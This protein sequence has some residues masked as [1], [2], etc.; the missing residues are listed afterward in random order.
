VAGDKRTRP[1][2]RGRTILPDL[3]EECLPVGFIGSLDEGLPERGNFFPDRW[4]RLRRS[5]S[6]S[7]ACD[8]AGA[9][10]LHQETTA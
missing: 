2:D 8:L 1:S 4:F 7:E 6:T 3:T 10:P 5:L 9:R